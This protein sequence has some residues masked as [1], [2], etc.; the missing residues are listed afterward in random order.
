MFSFPHT[1]Q[2]SFLYLHLQIIQELFT[3]FNFGTD[4]FSNPLYIFNSSSIDTFTHD[5][6]YPS[7]IFSLQL[8]S[9]F[10]N[11]CHYFSL[12]AEMVCFF[13]I[14]LFNV[15]NYTVYIPGFQTYNVT[16]THSPSS[17]TVT[18]HTLISQFPHTKEIEDRFLVIGRRLTGINNNPPPPLLLSLLHNTV[19]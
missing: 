11:Y 8:Q 13:F 6:F 7:F 17:N 1:V 12:D 19:C 10:T 14:V 3:L 18:S 5:C 4:E 2:V 15:H 9:V 16:H